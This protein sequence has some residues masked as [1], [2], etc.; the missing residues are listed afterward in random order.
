MSAWSRGGLIA[1]YVALLLFFIVTLILPVAGNPD[2]T[3]GRKDVIYGYE[4]AG[5]SW[6]LLFNSYDDVYEA[7]VPSKALRTWLPTFSVVKPSAEPR[8]V[9]LRITSCLP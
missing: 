1:Y 9:T 8:G 3:M 7:I 4:A 6:N 2:T 5:F